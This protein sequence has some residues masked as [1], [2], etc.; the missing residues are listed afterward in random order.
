MIILLVIV[1]DPLAIM[2]VLAATESLKWRRETAAAVPAEPPAYEQD[3]GALTDEQ[4]AEIE[5][6]VSELDQKPEQSILEQHPYLNKEFV[7]FENLMP[8]V[9]PTVSRESTV[10]QDDDDANEEP[11]IKAAM[12]EWKRQHPGQTVK[13]QRE[14]FEQGRIDQL[15]WMSY[16]E[17]V[18]DN[19]VKMYRGTEF[20]NG[21]IKGDG[22]IKLDTRPTSIYKFN[23]VKWIAVDKTLSDLYTYDIVYIDWLIE[24]IA[25]GEYDPDLLTESE[26]SQISER[27]NQT[28]GNR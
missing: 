9:A 1:F 15:P 21:A 24:Q 12:R 25:A 26:Q 8:V 17:A 14:L 23:G 16:I 7:H 10:N 27:I 2:M 11:E 3:D 19:T 5:A 4:L 28:K 18:P 22:F 13:Y 6:A 20:P